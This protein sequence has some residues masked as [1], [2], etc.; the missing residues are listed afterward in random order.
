MTAIL[1]VENKTLSDIK[2]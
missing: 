2:N 1:Q